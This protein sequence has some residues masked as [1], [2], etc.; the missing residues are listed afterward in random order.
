MEW[1]RGWLWKEPRP[2]KRH[3]L[4]K[5]RRRFFVLT[6]D[7]LEWHVDEKIMPSALPRGRVFF[8]G[9]RVRIRRLATDLV[10]E[11]GTEV[12]VLRGDDL[13]GWETALR[14]ASRE[15]A[16]GGAIAKCHELDEELAAALRRGDIRL[17]RCA[18]V[19]VCAVLRRF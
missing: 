13:D 11:S 14:A 10:F 18:W 12:L 16:V 17:L 3:W 6:S 7:C 15:V 5:P 1:K 2:S 4:S 19:A 9:C 8:R